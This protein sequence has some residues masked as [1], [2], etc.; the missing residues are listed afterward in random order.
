MGLSVWYREDVARILASIVH[1]QVST[2]AAI[3]SR[4]QELTDTYQRG[5]ADAVVAM[6]IAFGVAVPSGAARQADQYLN[7]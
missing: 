3:P 7:G 5:Y 1:T 4:D 2:L 6:A